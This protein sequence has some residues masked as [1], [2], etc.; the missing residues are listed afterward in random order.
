MFFRVSRHAFG[1]EV[2]KIFENFKHPGY[3]TSAW[4]W[5]Y[6]RENLTDSCFNFAFKKSL[7]K[8]GMKKAFGNKCKALAL[9]ETG[10]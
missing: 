5:I 3:L 10:E 6:R 1:F 7:L 4:W 2:S 8:I 9:L